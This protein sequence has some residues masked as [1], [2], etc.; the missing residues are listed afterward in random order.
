MKY[1]GDFQLEIVDILDDLNEKNK[2]Y[3]VATLFSEAVVQQEFQGIVEQ[4]TAFAIVSVVLVILYFTF[5][6]ESIFL[7]VNGMLIITFSFSL[8]AI[9]YQGVFRINYMSNLNNLVIFIV[10]GIAADNVFVF[11]DAWRQSAH[12]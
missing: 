2:A 9:V 6:L 1:A 12:I 5:H 10:L 3:I 8:C 11:V 7:A 4:D